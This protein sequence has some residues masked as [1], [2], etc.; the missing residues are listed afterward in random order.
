KS[1]AGLDTGSAA[2]VQKLMQTATYKM[3]F[4][5]T[6][7]VVGLPA[8]QDAISRQARVVRKLADQVM[9]LIKEDE[10]QFLEDHSFLVKRVLEAADG[11]RAEETRLKETKKKLEDIKDLVSKRQS[12][13]KDYKADLARATKDTADKAAEIRT[14]SE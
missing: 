6:Q 5:R 11:L 8:L 2:Y 7:V 14:L 13:I 1:L 9:T 4:D 3:H 12:E 10:D